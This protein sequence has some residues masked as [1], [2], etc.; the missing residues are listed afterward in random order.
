[1]NPF[2]ASFYRRLSRGIA[3]VL[4]DLFEAASERL[5]AYGNTPPNPPRRPNL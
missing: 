1:M 4:A 5:R 2:S 3:L